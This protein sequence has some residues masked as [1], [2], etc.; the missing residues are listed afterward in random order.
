MP[1]SGNRIQF[2]FTYVLEMLKT[3]RGDA[4]RVDKTSWRGDAWRGFKNMTHV[5]I[6]PQPPPTWPPPRP[7]IQLWTCTRWPITIHHHFLKT[8]TTLHHFNGVSFLA[9]FT[10]IPQF[11]FRSV[12]LLK[13]KRCLNCFKTSL[14][15]FFYAVHQWS[16]NRNVG[17]KK[18]LAF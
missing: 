14:F 5:Q 3:H 17:E 15:Y 16:T 11:L 8:K 7:L 10:F 12:I 18:F 4:C 1:N 13:P 9:S 6:W 2:F